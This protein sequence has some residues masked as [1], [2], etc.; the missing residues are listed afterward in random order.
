MI[1][2]LSQ[3]VDDNH[4]NVDIDSEYLKA[5]RLYDSAVELSKFGYLDCRKC[6]TIDKTYEMF[7]IT[8]IGKRILYGSRDEITLK[9]D[10]N[11]IT[12]K[13]DKMGYIFE[14][15]GGLTGKIYPKELKRLLNRL[16]EFIDRY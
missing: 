15:T 7:S 6:K 12:L 11:S 5:N 16:E 8:E 2:L 1:A 14:I 10:T 4:N 3:F 13:K 9:N